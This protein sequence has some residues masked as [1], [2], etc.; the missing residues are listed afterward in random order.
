MTVSVVYLVPGPVRMVLYYNEYHF[1]GIRISEIG[2]GRDAVRRAMLHYKIYPN[3][4]LEQLCGLLW[5]STRTLYSFTV[6][7]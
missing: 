5:Q 4:L 7:E 2:K 3:T 1:D 6:D